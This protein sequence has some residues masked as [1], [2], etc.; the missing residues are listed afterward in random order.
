M[1]ARLFVAEALLPGHP[2]KLCDV[3]A[4]ALVEEAA[5]H[6]RRALC[7][8]EVAVNRSSVFVTGRIACRDAEAIDIPE[9]V[10]AVFVGAG[11][12]A[13]WEPSPEALEIEADLC[14][15][16]LSEAEGES[17]VLADDQAI[18]TGYAVD[19]P[20]M[21][22][23]PPEQCLAHRLARRLGRL[24]TEAPELQLGPNGK[25]ILLLEE[26][27]FPTRLA[28]FSASLQQAG[29]GASGG[30]FRKV[31]AV[32]KDELAEFAHAVPGFDARVPEAVAVNPG[33]NAAVGGLAWGNGHSGR[34]LVADAYGPRIPIGGG[35]HGQD[36][37]KVERAG[38]LMARR[39]ARGAV[40]TGV[41]RE[42]LVTLAFVPG[43]PTAQVVSLLGDGRLL[44]ASRWA[45]LLDLSLAGV[46]DRYAGRVALADVAR[47][48]HFTS[49]ELP[50]ER[51]HFD[52]PGALS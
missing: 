44:D 9:V 45:G 12:G 25:L 40:M 52:G 38:A 20:G 36:F 33:G 1:T 13:E 34:R 11:Y 21:N 37:Y 8:I 26:E 3:V 7:G 30:L 22:Y 5:R 24:R 19:L 18:V 2:D 17:R 39:L 46:G 50:W 14:L 10:R 31:L 32:L 35:L 15:S 23:L 27:Q 43:R 29:T 49:P 16:P 47:Y 28:G 51:L 41:C 4:D 48:G 6:Q 42:C